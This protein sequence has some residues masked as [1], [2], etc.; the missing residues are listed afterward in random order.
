M[1]EDP[2]PPSRVQPSLPAAVDAVPA[3]SVLHVQSAQGYS[4]TALARYWYFVRA[5]VDVPLDY[6][7][8]LLVGH[9]A[10]RRLVGAP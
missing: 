2:S 7:L 9:R 6:N 8:T 5:V 10:T 1:D 4:P 3:S